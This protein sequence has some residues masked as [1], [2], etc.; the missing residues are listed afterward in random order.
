[1]LMM[2][3]LMILMLI[4]ADAGAANYAFVD[5][6]AGAADDAFVDADNSGSGVPFGQRGG[7]AA[8]KASSW[9][10]CCSWHRGLIM[11]VIML[12]VMVLIMLM[13]M[14]IMEITTTNKI[15]NS[16]ELKTVSFE[17]LLRQACL[18]HLSQI[19]IWTGF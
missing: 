17:I 7:R 1:M 10:T 12:M 3:L 18:S 13:V 5:A 15:Q 8:A 2:V 9:A 4:D 19:V 14:A 6:D 16:S 11:I